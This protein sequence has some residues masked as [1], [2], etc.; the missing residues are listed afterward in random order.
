MPAGIR[1]RLGDGGT[2]MR[3][4][5]D[6][7]VGEQKGG[8]AVTASRDGGG[9]SDD[10]PGDKPTPA[11]TPPAKPGATGS[12]AITPPI[13]ASS[14]SDKTGTQAQ[15]SSSSAKSGSS[16]SSALG[17]APPSGTTP[18]S[19][20][21]P[22]Q[23]SGA[24]K[25][26]VPPVG[27]STSGTSG[28]T[29]GSRTLSGS[30]AGGTEPLKSSATG[31]SAVQPGAPTAADRSA[32]PGEPSKA[33]PSGSS[34][35]GS[36]ASKSTGSGTGP[37][38]AP[39]TS[40]LS[41][42]DSVTD[43]PILDMKAAK[44]KPPEKPSPAATAAPYGTAKSAEAPKSED[45]SVPGVTSA[46]SGG[47]GIAAAA[48]SGIVGGIVG[49]GL[50]IV[51]MQGAAPTPKKA[52]PRVEAL[53]KTVAGLAPRNVLANL[54]KRL[55]ATE[56]AA[57][58]A[59]SSAQSALA[60][61]DEAL[62]SGPAAP[63]GAAAAAAPSDITAR[64]DA[65][66]QRVSALQEEPGRDQPGDSKLSAVP[67]DE[68][69]V[70]L[71]DLDE[72]LKSLETKSAQPA[73]PPPEDLSPKL[74]TIESAIEARTKAN[75]ATDQA[76]GQRVDQLQKALDSG[77]KAA[78]E[79]A[80]QAASAS[81]QAAEA[82]QSQAQ[83]AIKA[84]DRRLAEQADKIASL[85]KAQEGSARAST[86]QAALRVVA[87]DR[88][89]TA[90]Q[91]GAPYADALATLRGGD[92]SDGAKF[93]PLAGFADTGAPSAARL[94]ELFRPIANRLATAQRQ[95]QSRKLAESGSFS[96]R[97]K[98]MASSIVQVEP[99]NANGPNAASP[100]TASVSEGDL[101]ARVQTALGLGD[102]DAAAQAFKALPDTARAEAGKFG[103][104]L[105]AVA[106]A[107]STARSLL[108]EAFKGLAAPAAVR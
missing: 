36:D 44:P 88:I 56:K 82:G 6:G 33:G 51:S 87:S 80:Q 4:N 98:N 43:G 26:T 91:T 42:S 95:A 5:R 49:A 8:E 34:A 20:S 79:T 83:D 108:A 50:F 11:S 106:S 61:V 55:A 13:S 92:A 107:R 46:A 28:A 69:T 37:S 90:L 38:A 2:R 77:F 18:S 32:K 17:A 76:L 84:V 21:S 40:R 86:L 65:L 81:R 52:D 67:S 19:A 104:T 74:A 94:A 35:L 68:N 22:S 16:S 85:D 75:E 96:D 15:P 58:T 14:S 71:A 48:L 1:S 25:G 45:S 63:A 102:V 78:S 64:L 66:D 29:A 93:A 70:R 7:I 100:V 97:L 12:G 53:E 31:S 105:D 89:A 72:R 99:V 9:K 30:P 41:P 103:T 62:K 3:N 54:D 59:E 24:S 73:S 10:R 27:S 39:S 47:L 101:V 57:S 23:A 60:R